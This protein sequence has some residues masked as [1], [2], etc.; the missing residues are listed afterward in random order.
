MTA[1]AGYF[2]PFNHI[3]G[4]LAEVVTATLSIVY[5]D[6]IDEHGGLTAAGAANRE[7]YRITETTAVLHL[8]TGQAFEVIL[9]T[10]IT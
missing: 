3:N 5:A 10:A 8:H 9:Q 6:T 7:Q 4:D 1:A 2:D